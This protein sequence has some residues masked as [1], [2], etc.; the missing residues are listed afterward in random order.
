VLAYETYH[1]RPSNIPM[2]TGAKR[3]VILGKVTQNGGLHNGANG[4][5]NGLAHGNA[6]VNGHK[7][8]NTRSKL[9]QATIAPKAKAAA[10]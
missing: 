2:A 10:R 5:H 9:N 6:L 8:K 4:S 3:S 1:A 7:P